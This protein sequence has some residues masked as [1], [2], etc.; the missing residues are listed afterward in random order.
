MSNM[1]G[2]KLSGGVGF[3]LLNVGGSQMIKIRSHSSVREKNN[4]TVSPFVLLKMESF[5]S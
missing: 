1:T 4:S 3:C 5:V 2:L